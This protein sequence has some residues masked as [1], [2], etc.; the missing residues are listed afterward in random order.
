MP[1][2]SRKLSEIG[3]K[4]NV[5]HK[6]LIDLEIRADIADA[7]EKLRTDPPN[8]LGVY[9]AAEPYSD[10]QRKL[11]RTTENLHHERSIRRLRNL[12]FG[13]GDVELRKQL[14]LKDREEGQ[15]TIH[16]WQEE[17]AEATAKF[18]TARSIHKH[19]WV[20]SSICGI[21]FIAVGFHFFG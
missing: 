21:V 5:C 13:V 7:A 19:W 17:L 8:Y 9:D 12:Y 20:W 11:E 16:Y 2:S 1:M 4:A 10:E 3:N 14:I 15:I 6:A 18:E